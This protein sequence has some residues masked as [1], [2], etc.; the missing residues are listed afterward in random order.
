MKVRNPEEL[1]KARQ[2]LRRLERLAKSEEE[3]LQAAGK[4]TRRYANSDLNEAINKVGTQIE[5]YDRAN[6]IVEKGAVKL[7]HVGGLLASLAVCADSDDRYD[8]VDS[9]TMEKLRQMD[10]SLQSFGWTLRI[11]FEKI[12]QKQENP[13]E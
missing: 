10:A 13:E 8:R 2:L 7:V 12:E 4:D 5:M 3:A 6:L 11:S 9:A 1:K